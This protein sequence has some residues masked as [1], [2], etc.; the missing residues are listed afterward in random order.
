MTDQP[1]PGM[2]DLLAL[3]KPGAHL[4]GSVAVN[5]EFAQQLGVD[6][7]NFPKF[8]KVDD[9][10]TFPKANADIRWQTDVD[11]GRE[12][13]DYSGPY[14]PDLRYTDFSK[15]A[16][17]TRIIPWSEA[18]LQLCVDGWADEITRRY[19]ADT[20]ADIEWAAWT[21]QIAPEIDRWKRA[22]LP[23][24]HHYED[25]NPLVPE[26]RRRGTRIDYSGPAETAEES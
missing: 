3:R 2:D 4:D 20:M 9:T 23:A 14:L 17:V 10:V 1:A 24:G 7:V 25:P 26:D 8:D 22:Y 16:L 18:Y 15:D 5:D 6:L 12:L 13:D 11:S 19:D 21:D